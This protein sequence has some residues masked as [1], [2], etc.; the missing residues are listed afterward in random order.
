MYKPTRKKVTELAAETKN[1]IQPMEYDQPCDPEETDVAFLVYANKPM[2][3]NNAKQREQGREG[4]GR[5]GGRKRER[6]GGRGERF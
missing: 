6:G 2:N 4:G 5:E 1:P 3:R